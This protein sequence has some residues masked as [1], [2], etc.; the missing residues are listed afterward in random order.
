[1][2]SK[3]NLKRNSPE[4]GLPAWSVIAMGSALAG[5]VD[6]TYAIL[7]GAMR[8]VPMIAIPQ[9]VA[10][11]LLGMK[12]FREGIASAALGCALH[13][14]IIFV[15]ASIYFLAS[16]RLGALVR[17]PLMGGLF[18]GLIIYAVMHEIV[19]PLSFAPAFKSTTMSF[20]AELAMHIVVIG[21]IIAFSAS[22]ASIR[23]IGQSLEGLAS[24][25]D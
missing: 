20:I 4:S 8:G 11:G 6:L 25:A 13:F 18:Y 21:P 12:A 16:R 1:M 10:S 2:N 5:A 22:R 23:R 15:A 17:R 7:A 19:L 3:N 14:S 24:T 9:S